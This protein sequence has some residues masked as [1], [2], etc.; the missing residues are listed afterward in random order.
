MP[1]HP[2]KRIRRVTIKLGFERDWYLILVAAAIGLV[3][4]GVAIAFI[5]PLRWLEHWGDHAD[6]R[7]LLW[8]VPIAPVVGALMTGLVI[9]ALRKENQGPGVSSV[10]YA[11]HRDKAR[12]PFRAAIRKWIAST[13]TIGS[14]G[15]AGAEGPIVTIGAVIGSN[16][17]RIL[18]TNPQNTATLLGCGAA[19]GL[20]SVFNAP[21][22]GIFFVMEILLRDFSLRTFTPIVI[23]AVISSAASQAFLGSGAIFDPP[24]SFQGEAFHVAE[25]PNYL[26]LGVVCGLAAALFIKALQSTER[27]FARL[28]MHAVLKPVIGGALLGLIGLVFIVTVKPEVGVPPFF[29]NGYPVIRQLLDPEYYKVGESLKP[30][31]EILLIIMALG[32]LKAV[33][34]CLTIG[35]GGSGGLFAPSLLIGAAVGGTM[36]YIINDLG[37]FP[38]ATPAHYALVGM[39]AMV[40]ATTHAPLTAILMVYEITRS[41]EIM[42]PLMFAAVISTIVARVVHRESVYTG[43]LA[44]LGVRIGSLSDLTILRRLSVRDVPL[45]PAVTI[46]PDES[47]Q[48]LLELSERHTATDFVVVGDDREYIGLVTGEDLR[49]ALVYREA[50]PLLQVNELMR[51]DVPTVSREDTLDIVL[52]LFS[53]HDAQAL[54][55]SAHADNG[56]I[57]GL[58]TRSRL[59][60]RYQAVLSR[61]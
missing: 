37:W 9:N 44:E 15:S 35:S 41:Y 56:A 20:A 18:G 32:L 40:G 46:G 7:T 28:H 43:K 31:S 5:T 45:M 1:R 13:T 21:F 57:V 53:R 16:V 17:G 24:Q 59:L 48:R 50:I 33:G 26:L 36:G 58:I 4:A 11:I 22:A 51:A 30:A 14:G 39:A 60:A 54:P 47:A 52:D 34:T 25:I 12:M 3:M 23:A 10:M 8:L 42:L 6:A 29:G 27:R 19:A 38:S 2:L 49:S 55:V 61:D